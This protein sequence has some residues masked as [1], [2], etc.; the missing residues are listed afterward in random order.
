VAEGV[1]ITNG[2]GVPPPRASRELLAAERLLLEGREGFRRAAPYL[3]LF[4]NLFADGYLHPLMREDPTGH[5]LALFFFGKSSL[6][7]GLFLFHYLTVSESIL[8]RID[9]LPVPGRSRFSFVMLGGLRTPAVS[10][11]LATDLMFLVVILRAAPAAA[12]VACA[13]LTLLVLGS[14]ALVSTGAFVLR[15]SRYPVTALGA[16]GALGFVALGTA[17][18]VFPSSGLLGLV[19]LVWLTVNAVGA[20][21]QGSLGLALAWLAALGL[22][23]GAILVL[24]RTLAE[25]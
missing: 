19:P 10:G 14:I 12:A 17:L 3:L 24:G 8:G 6:I 5:V 21:L 20:I 4:L 9:H 23:A 1:S 13:G 16:L 2:L 18:I 25:G 7:A 11:L 22:A 15:R